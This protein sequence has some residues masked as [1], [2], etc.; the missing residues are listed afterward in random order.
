MSS[1][2]NSTLRGYWFLLKRGNFVASSTGGKRQ[3][4]FSLQV[5]RGLRV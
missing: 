3:C 1:Y 4:G 2:A 5:F